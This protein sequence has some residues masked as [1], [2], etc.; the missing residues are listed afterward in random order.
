M[1]NLITFKT[2]ATRATRGE[3]WCLTVDLLDS[4]D[5]CPRNASRQVIRDQWEETKT[6]WT[7]RDVSPSTLL[8][9]AEELDY[10]GDT[11]TGWDEEVMRSRRAFPRLARE[12]RALVAQCRA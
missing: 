9:L 11:T 3:I 5:P 4:S 2:R 12:L 7:L 8:F 10:F 6:T 1:T